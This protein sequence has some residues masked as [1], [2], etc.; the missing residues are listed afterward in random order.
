MMTTYFLAMVV[1][2]YLLITGLLLV[3]KRN[4]VVSAM[5]DIIGQ[6]GLLFFIAA[7]TLIVG[8]LMVASHNVWVM[9][10]PVVIT[11]L[12]WLAV[13][14]GIIRMFCPETVHMMWRKISAKPEILTVSG[15]IVLIIGLFLLFKVYFM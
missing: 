8:L 13:I 14:S 2:W 1:G 12:G 9:G 10:W 15:V 7:V 3:F 6:N 4:V 5:N 11:L